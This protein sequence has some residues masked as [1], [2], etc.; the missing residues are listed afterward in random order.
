MLGLSWSFILWSYYLEGGCLEQ[1]ILLVWPNW[2]VTSYINLS[3]VVSITLLFNFLNFQNQT[4]LHK[5]VMHNHMLCENQTKERIIL[6]FT[7][8]FTCMYI[9]FHMSTPHWFTL[10]TSVNHNLADCTYRTSHC[11]VWRSIAGF[12]KWYIHT[13]M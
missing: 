12:S 10:F 3:T 5:H 11:I 8:L 2:N 6:V 13:Y 7:E 4:S 1:G 9:I